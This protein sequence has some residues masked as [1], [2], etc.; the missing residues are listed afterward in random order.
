[1]LAKVVLL[2]Y[3]SDMDLRRSWIMKTSFFPIS[4]IEPATF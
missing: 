4:V 1:V 3:L 2:Q